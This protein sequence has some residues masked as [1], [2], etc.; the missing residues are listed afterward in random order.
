MKNLPHETHILEA[1]VVHIDRVS[2]LFH[3]THVDVGRCNHEGL[4][5]GP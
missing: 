5:P 4:V 3:V 1:N 2:R